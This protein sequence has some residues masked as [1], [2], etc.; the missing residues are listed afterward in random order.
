MKRASFV[1]AISV[2]VAFAVPVSPGSLA[3]TR[4]PDTSPVTGMKP[5]RVTAPLGASAKLCRREKR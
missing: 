4:T 1:L 2:A 5:D 3:Q